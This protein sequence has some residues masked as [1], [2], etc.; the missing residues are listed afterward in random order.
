MTNDD[1][2]TPVSG[3]PPNHVPE[4]VAALAALMATF[5]APWALCGGWAVDA[6][7]GRETRE[8]GDVDLSVFDQDQPALFEHLRGWQMLA[9]DPTWK[10][11][12]GDAWWDGRPILGHPSHIHA[13]PP[14]RSGAVPADGIATTE[15]GFWLDIQLNERAG[16]EWLI[17]REPPI[18]VPLADAVAMSPWGLPTATPEVLLAF[19]ARDLRRRDRLDFEALLP[20]LDERERDWLRQAI[21][22]MGHPWMTALSRTGGPE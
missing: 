7:L 2:S 5:P 20:R 18:S 16:A 15:D 4:P 11:A 10:P 19:K 21:S 9:H 14:E 22:L 17:S 13:R 3:Q 6:W 12:E 8:H 1:N